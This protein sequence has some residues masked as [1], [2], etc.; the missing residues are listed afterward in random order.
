M[1]QFIRGSDA[2]FNTL[3]ARARRSCVRFPNQDMPAGVTPRRATIG[4]E[5]DPT[6]GVAR[7]LVDRGLTYTGR[8]EDLR[9]WFESGKKS[10][11]NFD[12]LRSWI[13]TKLRAAF[14]STAPDATEC[15]PKSEQDSS[16][17]SDVDLDDV[18]A[19]WLRIALGR[20]RS[21]EDLPS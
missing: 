6:T 19:K 12:A 18:D 2:A 3:E 16:D 5:I 21:K 13:A 8:S 20:G 14:L 15:V 9:E 4:F 10:F 17:G 11:D 7:L 1:W